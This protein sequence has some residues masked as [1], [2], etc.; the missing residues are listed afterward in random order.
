MENNIKYGGFIILKKISQGEQIGY[1]YREKSAIPQLNG[2]TLLSVSDDDEYV[3]NPKNFMIVSAETI[4]KIAPV[5]IEIFDAL[6]GTDLCW[7]YEEDV[8]TG[9]YCL[10]DNREVTID[11]ILGKN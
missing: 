7:I 6:Y 3:N 1:S 11:E 5:M 9:F 8:H 2:W 4:M 10:S